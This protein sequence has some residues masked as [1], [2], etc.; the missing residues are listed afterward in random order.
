MASRAPAEAMAAPAGA[1]AAPTPSRHRESPRL[2]TALKVSSPSDSA[3][4]EAV[5]TARRVMAAPTALP[6]RPMASRTPLQAARAASPSRAGPP[7]SASIEAAIGQARGGGRPLPADVTRFMGRRFGTDFGAVR[8]HTDGRAENLATRLG[9]RAF[10]FGR[11]IFFNAGQFHPDTPEGMELIAHELTH[12]IQQREVVQRAVAVPA[13]QASAQKG[14]QGLLGK[15]LDWIADKAAYLPGFR[16]LTLVAGFNPINMSKVER[17]GANLVRAVV[18]L[19]PGGALIVD[20]LE[21]S[22]AFDKAGAWVDGQFQRLAPIGHLLRILVISFLGSIGI[23]DL[24]SP[25]TVWERAK[26]LFASPLARLIEFGKTMIVGVV[27]IIVDKVAP[28]LLPLLRKAKAWFKEILKDLKRF[29]RNLFAAVKLGFTQFGTNWVQ[30]LTGALLGWLT[31]SL[32]G[33]AIYLPKALTGKEFAKFGLSILGI[34]WENVRAKLVQAFG[35]ELAVKSLEGMGGLITTLKDGGIDALGVRLLEMMSNLKEQLIQEI[36][37]LVTR[38]I[39]EVGLTRL[40]P[41]VFPPLGAVINVIIVIYQTVMFVIERFKQMKIVV[42]AFIDS[43]TNIAAGVIGTAANRIETAMEGVLS[44]LISY[45]ARLVGLGQLSKTITRIVARIRKPIDEG[46]NKLVAWLVSRGKNL[47]KNVKQG[48]TAAIAW[49][50]QK[51]AFTN[52]SGEQHS[53]YFEGAEEK[54]RLMIASDKPQ[55]VESY[56]AAYSDKASAEFKV[57]NEVFKRDNRLIFTPQ[58]KGTDESKRRK[59]VAETLAE[60]ME[61]FAKLSGQPE[62]KPEDYPS[63]TKPDYGKLEVEYLV[64]DIPT[65]TDPPKQDTG[66]PGWAQVQAAGLTTGEDP[67]VRMHIISAELGGEGVPQNLIPAPTSINSGYRTFEHTIRDFA[68]DKSDKLRRVV[69]A[70]FEVTRRGIFAKSITGTAGLYGWMGPTASPKWLKAKK[71]SLHK[72]SQIPDPLTK[73]AAAISLNYGTKKQLLRLNVDNKL[74]ALIMAGRQ[75]STIDV[76]VRKMNEQAAAA[77]IADHAAQIQSIIDNPA[78]VLR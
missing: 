3:E 33:T 37:E 20:A 74:V 23:A 35:S 41:M 45:V 44:L 21:D 24:A 2:R 57:A 61:A 32:A 5:A 31:G 64:G 48:V 56:L 26:H 58:A 13:A 9:A 68:Q 19:V 12:T 78:V 65:G 11:D 39:M 4:R 17:S 15:A 53:L 59:Q 28:A 70:K 7:G 36:I 14:E 49:W 63:T 52:K 67:W 40:L 34:T 1:R 60:I 8:I 55:T 71:S 69:W 29:F 30:H 76:F 25:A 16:L 62:P 6:L 42:Q 50:K 73:D 10:T 51:I 47:L 27:E 43:F 66:T 75:Y 54:A 77:G 22:G 46:L 38:E 72:T 18:E